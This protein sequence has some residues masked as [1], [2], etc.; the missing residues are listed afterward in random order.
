MNLINLPGKKTK[1][2]TSARDRVKTPKNDARLP[3]SNKGILNYGKMP[4]QNEQASVIKE[5][6]QIV[7]DRFQRA[8]NCIKDYW[9]APFVTE[10]RDKAFEEICSAVD[11]IAPIGCGFFKR[12]KEGWGFWE[13]DLKKT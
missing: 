6:E 2:K 7:P 3:D 11:K 9:N 10:A 4:H 1:K 5:L 8:N 12:G 13:L